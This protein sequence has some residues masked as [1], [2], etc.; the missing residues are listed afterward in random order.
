MSVYFIVS[1]G[2]ESRQARQEYDAYIEKVK[3]IVERNG[4]RY[5]VR[6]EKITHLSAAW[7]PDRIIIIEFDSKEAVAQCFSSKEYKEIENLRTNSV[8]SNAIIVES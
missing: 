3:P 2:I 5:I 1:V 4:G 8:A 6:S 7:N